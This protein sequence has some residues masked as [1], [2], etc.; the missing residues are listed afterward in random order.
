MGELTAVVPVWDA[1][2]AY[3]PACLQAIRRQRAA[4][5]IVVV[6]NAST[7][8]LPLL[9]EEVGVV[10]SAERLTA[11]GARNLGLAAVDTPFVVFADADDAVRPG[12]W[13]F[14]LERLRADPALV[15][16]AAQL[17]WVDGEGRRP[18]SSPRPHVYTHLN[19]RPRLFSLYMTLR[20]A[21]PTTT[22]TVFRTEAVVD[23][24]GYG[25]SEVAE[26]WALA[27]A[28]ALRGRVEQHARPGAD[29][30][31]HEGSLF[32]RPL[33]RSQVARGM[34]DV[35]RRLSA[36]PRTPFWLRW[37]LPPIAGFHELKAIAA[38]AR[39]GHRSLRGARAA[40]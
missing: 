40:G 26:D 1:Y 8:P 20:M 21:L 30:L 16:A 2:M 7:V 36:D 18:A 5:R 32:N 35:R 10:H 19:G 11:G 13:S 28:V 12:T 31:V 22:V 38:V 34:R 23:A 9:G 27:A 14:L 4:S 25:D 39:P 17:W 29:V 6:D 3:L 24:G 33:P 15:A 37:L